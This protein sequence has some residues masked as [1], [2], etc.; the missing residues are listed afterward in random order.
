MLNAFETRFQL[1]QDLVRIHLR[2]EGLLQGS[3]RQ[4]QP[5]RRRKSLLKPRAK[6]G[7]MAPA[8]RPPPEWNTG[9]VVR[10]ETPGGQLEEVTL[11][12]SAE[13]IRRRTLIERTRA[14]LRELED[15]TPPPSAKYIRNRILLEQTRRR[16][17]ESRDSHTS[18]RR[19]LS[20]CP[21]AGP[22][23]FLVDAAAAA[24]WRN[25][26]F[27]GWWSW[28]E[29]WGKLASIFIGAYY[30][31]VAGRWVVTLLFSLKVLY[32]EHGF[33]PNLLWG[34][35][36]GQGVFPMHFYRRW[37]RFKQHFSQA[38]GR[39][40]ARAPPLTAPHEYLA[41]N[42]VEMPP[43]PRRNMVRSSVYPELPPLK[44]TP[45]D[46][47]GPSTANYARPERWP[48]A[49]E[50]LPCQQM[51]GADVSSQSRP[52][53]TAVATAGDLV[54]TTPPA[55]VAPQVSA[56]STSVTSV[57][58]EGLVGPPNPRL[59]GVFRPPEDTFPK[60]PIGEVMKPRP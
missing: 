22:D 3:R 35:G 5:G 47:D 14:L 56:P 53:P 40:A 42:E 23:V 39:E 51:L 15:G 17:R 19:E 6:R 44:H 11:P 30:L 8:Q 20:S 26:L 7:I 4:R 60:G 9:R 1:L 50:T 37:R 41:L 46:T 45:G 36:P 59:S 27:G 28:L 31:Y 43:L 21:R 16:P 25:L 52:S 57:G 29:K 38:D 54:R 48:T 34:L 32:D 49:G 24:D 33:G 10:I 55:A 58:T 2:R 12:P 18:A 13:D